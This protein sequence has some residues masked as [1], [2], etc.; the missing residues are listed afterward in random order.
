MAAVAGAFAFRPTLFDACRLLTPADRGEYELSKA[1]DLLL[2]AGREVTTVDV[3]GWRHTV[4]TPED[5][6]TV[7]QRLAAEDDRA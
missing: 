2:A 5:V 4:N 3:A 6:P 7:E 1:V